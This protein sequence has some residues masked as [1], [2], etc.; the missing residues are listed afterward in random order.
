MVIMWTYLPH[1]DDGIS[2][3]DK[4]ND[5]GFNESGDHVIVFFKQGQDLQHKTSHCIT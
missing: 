3:K 1:T 4:K 5:E 2:D